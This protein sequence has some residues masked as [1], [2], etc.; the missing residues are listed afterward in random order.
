MPLIKKWEPAPDVLLGLW[1]VDEK[2]S[3]FSV[4]RDKNISVN[5]QLERMVA[6]ALLH[7]M[8]GDEALSIHHNLVGAPYTDEYYISVSHTKGYVAVMLSKNNKVAVDVEWK[9][10]RVERVATRFLREDENIF[11]STAE[12]LLCW[13]GK[14]TL[15]KLYSQDDLSFS[16]MKI[17][18]FKIQSRGSFWGKNI[19]RNSNVEIFY[20]VTNQYTLTYT[21][22]Q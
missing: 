4:A 18:P 19:L 2:L 5:R 11:L 12:K 17:L 16:Q 14:E 20:E 22:L 21:W 13:C 15:Y 3:D 6:H 8:T 10:N 1:K 7:Q 9:S